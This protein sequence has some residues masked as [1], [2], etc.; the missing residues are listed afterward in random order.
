MR[1]TE[2][3]VGR[4]DRC[5][6]TFFV[7]QLFVRFARLDRTEHQHDEQIDEYNC[8]DDGEDKHGFVRC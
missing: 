6:A 7:G 2:Q 3:H 5:F 4:V 1:S 8:E